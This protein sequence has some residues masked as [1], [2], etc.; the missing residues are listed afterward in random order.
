MKF[1]REDTKVVKGIAICLM[2]C[3][4]LFAFPTK[5]AEPSTFVSLFSFGQTSFATY[6]GQFSMICMPVFLFIGGY[7][8]YLSALKTKDENALVIG[9]IAGLYKLVWQVFLLSLP[10]SIYFNRRLG[11]KLIISIIYNFLTLNCGFNEEWWFILPYAVM[12][13]L[14]PLIRRLIDRKNATLVGSVLFIVIYSLFYNYFYPEILKYPFF[15]SFSASMFQH[16]LKEVLQI[17]PAFYLGCLAAKYVLL[18]KIKERLGGRPLWCAA[19]LAVMLGIFYIH[20]YN[21]QKYEFFDAA[22]LVCCITVWLPLDFM[23]YP[24]KV[25]RALGEESTFMWLT[26]TFFCYYWCQRLVYAPKY[27]PLIFLWLLALSFAAA[28]LVRTFWKYVSVR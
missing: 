19:A 4:H 5:V 28:K 17:F 25:F 8:T 18:D 15:A 9:K 27:A 26:H 11:S 22:V 7:G 21:K 16:R 20:L 1:T 3:H 2:L 13:A 10:F 23:K 6:L 14:F 12:I 24:W